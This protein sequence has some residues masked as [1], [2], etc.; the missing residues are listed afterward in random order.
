LAAA[1]TASEEL[2]DD[3]VFERMKRDDDEPAARGQYGF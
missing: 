1:G 2:L 3:A